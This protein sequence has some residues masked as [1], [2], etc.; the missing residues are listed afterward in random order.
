MFPEAL[1]NKLCKNRAEVKGVRVP[2]AVLFEERFDLHESGS[3]LEKKWQNIRYPAGFM[4]L[5]MNFTSPAN[6]SAI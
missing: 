3:F 1:T 4:Q 2:T 6:L 5:P